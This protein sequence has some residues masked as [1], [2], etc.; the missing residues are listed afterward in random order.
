MKFLFWR[1]REKDLD[2]EIESHLRMAARDSEARGASRGEAERL[3]RV[4]F[5]NVGLVKETTRGMWRSVG[6]DRFPKDLRYALRVL[7]RSPG[8][9]TIAVLSL[10]LG[11]GANTAI[12]TVVNALMLRELPVDHPEQ[13]VT[14]STADNGDLSEQWPYPTFEKFRELTNIFSGISAIATVFRSNINING[15]GGGLDPA[16]VNVA[17][18][19][20]TYFAT[21]GVQP[22]AGRLFTADDDLVP[23]GHPVA[24]ISYNYWL[25]RFSR[26][27][28]VVGRIFTLNQTSYRILGVTRAG[29]TGDW[30]EI[31]TDIW[32]PI[33]MQSE[34]MLERPGLLANPNPPWVRVVAR[35][36]PGVQKAQAQAA[37][38]VA[39][40]KAVREWRNMT[41]RMVDSAMKR[42]L[43]LESSAKGFSWRRGAFRQPLIILMVTVG[44]VLLIAC[45]NIANL[46]LARSAAREREMS[47]RLSLGAGRRDIFWLL[48]TES[49][50]VGASGGGLGILFAA[51]GSSS[52]AKFLAS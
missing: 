6:F 37:L 43:I 33:A 44:L 47:V 31:P 21:L 41:P 11:I 30:V 45:V 8:F 36:R 32:V 29:F 50:I 27:E 3:A 14:I 19:S 51:W 12:F 5:G 48:L 16:Q 40:A 25:R 22:A 1:R 7:G 2:D 46:L 18:I 20:G 35:V 4:E 17:M 9:T 39:F 34:V 15:P 13:L 49:L 52:L 10:A 24:V 42:S 23:D 26:G 38:K 28:D